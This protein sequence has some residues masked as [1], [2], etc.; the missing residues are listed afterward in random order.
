MDLQK[1][2]SAA[3]P[4]TADQQQALT[5][6][7][8][9]AQQMEALFVDLLFKEMRKSAPQ[10]SL[11]GKTSN[12]EATFRDMLDEKRAEELAKSGS[13]GIGAILERQLRASVV[14][15]PVLGPA[16]RRPE[17]HP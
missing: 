12:A 6:L 2:G 14:G 5:K 11:T 7:H 4:L 1:V 9:A 15:E 17:G 16:A 13:L 10:A 3:A 8:T